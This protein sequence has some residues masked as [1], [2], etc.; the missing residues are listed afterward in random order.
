MAL[1]STSRAYVAAVMAGDD[2]LAGR[3]G[4]VLDTADALDRARD[5]RPTRLRDAALAYAA[6]GVAVFPLRPRGKQPLTAHGFHDATTGAAQ[7]AAWWAATP[8]ANIGLPTGLTFDVIDIDGRDGLLAMVADRHG[9]D[10]I[11][12]A[13]TTRPAGHHWYVPVA[14]HGNRTALI[15]GVDYRGTGGYVVAPP[16]I[17]ATGRA[18]RWL[19]PLTSAATYGE[20]AA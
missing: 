7:V 19:T 17:G 8:D 15:P 10:V 5:Q 16:S 13:T 18:Y 20:V 14:G 4:T 3:L 11:A 9:L 2:N 1:D 12:R 6:D